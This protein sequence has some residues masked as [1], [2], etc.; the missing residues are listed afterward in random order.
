MTKSKGTNCLSFSILVWLTVV[1]LALAEGDTQPKSKLEQAVEKPES[2]DR[3]RYEDRIHVGM[4]WTEA[5]AIFR[6]HNVPAKEVVLS[7]AAGESGKKEL[8]VKPQYESLDALYVVASSGDVKKA[9]VEGLSWEIRYEIDGKLPMGDR[10]HRGFS[11]QSLRI[12]DLMRH[13]ADEMT[14]PNRP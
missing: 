6:K 9:T 13:P 10:A 4:K 2:I 1:G 12:H 7:T 11:L 14:P 3:S 5:L 8:I